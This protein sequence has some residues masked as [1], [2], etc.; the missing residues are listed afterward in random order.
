[1]HFFVDIL[2][3]VSY[4]VAH[5][6]TSFPATLKFLFIKIVT[7]NFFSIWFKRKLPLNNPDFCAGGIY[8]LG[9]GVHSGLKTEKGAKNNVKSLFNYLNSGFLNAGKKKFCQKTFTSFIEDIS[10]LHYS[11]IVLYSLFSSLWHR[12]GITHLR[13]WST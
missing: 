6:T 10:N 11:L 2:E 9:F 12:I 1:M 13:W 5:M 8:G 7:L 4:C 3:H